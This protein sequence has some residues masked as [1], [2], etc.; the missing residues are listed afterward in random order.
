MNI[1][2]VWCRDPLVVGLSLLGGL[3]DGC[4]SWRLSKNPSA[5]YRL[6]RG[7]GRVLTRGHEPRGAP[8]HI[9]QHRPAVG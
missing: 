1:Y 7:L 3:R 8:A 4:A 5:N 6:R 2:S 9:P